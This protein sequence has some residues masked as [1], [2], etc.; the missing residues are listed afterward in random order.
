MQRLSLAAPV[1]IAA[2]TFAASAAA[3]SR[4]RHVIAEQEFGR[5]TYE[6]HAAHG[7][8]TL[9]IAATEDEHADTFFFTTT[10]LMLDGVSVQSVVTNASDVPL[11]A[12]PVMVFGGY[13]Q[14]VAPVRVKRDGGRMAVTWEQDAAMRMRI[15]V[16]IEEGFEPR[17]VVPG[18]AE[19]H[20]NTI[21]AR[22][23][24]KAQWTCNLVHNQPAQ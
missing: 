6:A 1:A 16:L 7:E 22:R 5:W 18:I 3:D 4:E 12:E 8:P 15:L 11:E 21:G 19:W 2:A 10:G 9:C 23:A 17:L 13:D 14:P 24:L 20:I